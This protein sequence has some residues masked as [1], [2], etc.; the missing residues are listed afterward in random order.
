MR[1]VFSRRGRI[2]PCMT[3]TRG[4]CVRS[5]VNTLMSEGLTQMQRIQSWLM[6]GSW[7]NTE[8]SFIFPNLCMCLC[9]IGAIFI[10]WG[11]MKS[12]W[13]SWRT[14]TH[15]N[16]EK[17]CRLMMLFCYLVVIFC[18]MNNPCCSIYFLCPLNIE[19]FHSLPHILHYP[20]QKFY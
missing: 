12:Y 19:L 14:W 5:E 2:V 3:L 15:G 4:L 17:I 8:L 9:L 20:Q 16:G 18:C 6:T 11:R 10:C 7:N 13:E 1:Q